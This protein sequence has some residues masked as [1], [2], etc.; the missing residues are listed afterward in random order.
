MSRPWVSFDQVEKSR[1]LYNK[2]YTLLKMLYTLSNPIVLKAALKLM[3]LP[4]GRPRRPYPEFT[5]PRL[6]ELK[7]LM[8][9]LEIIKG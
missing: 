2:Y 4:S 5:G 8:M 9:E 6:E 3:G 7:R 1:F